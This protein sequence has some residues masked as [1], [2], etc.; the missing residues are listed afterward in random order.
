[1]RA[2]ASGGHRNS[3]K[4]RFRVIVQKYGFLYNK[5][6]EKQHLYLIK[7]S[8]V[9]TNK[10]ES[11]SID[12][13]LSRFFL[14][15]TILLVLPAL[16]CSLPG[17][18][19]EAAQQVQEILPTLEQAVTE[20]SATQAGPAAPTATN[21]PANTSVPTA[22]PLVQAGNLAGTGFA[23]MG[24]FGSGMTCLDESGWHT[25]NESNSPLGGDQIDD[26]ALC[27]DDRIFLAHTFGVSVF[28]GQNWN[29]LPDG[30]FY[31]ADAVAC[32]A[33]SRIWVAHWEGASYYD[34]STWTKHSSELMATGDAATGLVNDIAVSP[35]GTVWTV[36]SNSVAHYD[37]AQWT[38]Y[39]QGQGLDDLYFFSSILV[40]STGAPWAAHSS[41]LLTFDGS[42]WSNIENS[43][44]S[45][46]DD[47]FIDS[48]DWVWVATLRGVYV[49]H[50]AGWSN[51]NM[52][53]SGLSTDSA[54]SVFVDDNGRLW[55]GTQWGLNIFDGESWTT[56]HMH[57]SGLADH[58]IEDI[59][60]AGGGPSLPALMSKATGSISGSIVFANGDP[61]GDAQIEACVEILGFMYFGSSP[62]SDQPYLANSSTDASGVFTLTDLPVGNYVLTVQLPDESWAQLETEF[63]TSEFEPVAE[64]EN[65]DVGQLTVNEE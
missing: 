63:G 32:D 21:R 38:V 9:F 20:V 47:I 4:G 13:R 10:E 19:R 2:G 62:C 11:M 44:I 50:D 56:Y 28:D 23:C 59:V 25:F 48:R 1:L 37:G 36:T 51:Y 64:G 8:Q 24:T 55:V 30:D 26:M 40:D 31:S 43:D 49:Y 57:T 33:L 3:K 34:G 5:N 35:D 39:Q 41:G 27:P 22:E 17:M 60:V 42:N 45:S 16:A 29:E 65:T 54:R 58:D 52:S 46:I 53:N 61:L 15:F 14:V 7:F 18:A 12:R 6:T